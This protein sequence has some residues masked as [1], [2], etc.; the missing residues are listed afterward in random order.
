M[1]IAEKLA[2]LVTIR[3]DI[4]TALTDKG[5]TAET[6][7][8][9]DFASDIADIPSGGNIGLTLLGQMAAGCYILN[10]NIEHGS[11][12]ATTF[13]Y[14]IPSEYMS[15]AALLIKKARASNRGRGGLY[16]S[17]PLDKPV[18]ASGVVITGKNITT[19]FNDDSNYIAAC[20]AL[21]P[22]GTYG[23]FAITVSNVAS[24]EPAPEFV[25]L[26]KSN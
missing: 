22:S 21:T 15:H 14:E 11:G 7:N 25:I 10:G 12:A 26:E 2:Q 20:S 8:F 1:S 6:H 17:N 13:V 4:R 5:V 16:T 9:S 24:D 19:G 3:S 23:Y 18:P